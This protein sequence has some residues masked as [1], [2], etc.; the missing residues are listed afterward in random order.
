[1]ILELVAVDMAV[2]CACLRY[3]YG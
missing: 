3:N 1:V 2:A